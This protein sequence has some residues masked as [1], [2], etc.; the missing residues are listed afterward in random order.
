M[1]PDGLP[2]RPEPLIG[3]EAARRERKRFIEQYRAQGHYAA[4]GRRILFADLA[5][6]VRIAAWDEV[7]AEPQ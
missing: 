6:E 1:G 2:S 4:V 7:F 5:R 3:I